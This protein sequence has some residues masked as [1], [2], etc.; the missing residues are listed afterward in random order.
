M[1]GSEREGLNG[2]LIYDT[3]FCTGKDGDSTFLCA[4]LGIDDWNW[5]CRNL[6]YLY[7]AHLE[8]KV[9]KAQIEAFTTFD[10]GICGL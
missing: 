9:F 1:T 8:P 4:V 7:N 3:A 10:S 5:R 6:A 2:R